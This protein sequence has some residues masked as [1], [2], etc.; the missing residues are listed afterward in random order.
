MGDLPHCSQTNM[1]SPKHRNDQAP[2]QGLDSSWFGW[3]GQAVTGGPLSQ[4]E[5]PGVLVTDADEQRE[6]QALEALVD[7]IIAAM[8]N[9]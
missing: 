2:M 9:R 8:L 4:S 7:S 3:G 1:Q 6:D 5:R